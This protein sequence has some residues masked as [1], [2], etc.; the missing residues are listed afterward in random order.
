MASIRDEIVYN[1]LNNIYALTDFNIYNNVD[2]IYAFRKQSVLANKS[3]TKDSKLLESKFFK[4]D[5]WK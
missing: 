2:E 3:L 5:I 4:S 1:L